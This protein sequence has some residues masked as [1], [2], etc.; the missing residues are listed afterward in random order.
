MPYADYPFYV[1]IYRGNQI[2]ASDFPRLITRASSYLNSMTRANPP[3]E[4]LKM[5]ACAV[6]EAWQTNEQGGD[7]ASQSVGS[8]SKSFAQKKPKS[9]DQRLLDAAKLYLGNVVSNV[10]WL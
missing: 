6:A 4:S 5:A 3:E 7:L 8:W 9:D 10:R 2:A 1:S